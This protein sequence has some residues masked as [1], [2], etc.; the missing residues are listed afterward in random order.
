[1]QFAEIKAYL[2]VFLF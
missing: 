1:M 2:G